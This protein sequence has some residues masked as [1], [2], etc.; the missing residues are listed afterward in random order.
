MC[1]MITSKGD[2]KHW[3]CGKTLGL[4]SN[5]MTLLGTAGSGRG[6]EGIKSIPRDTAY[7]STVGTSIEPGLFT[8]FYAGEAEGHYITITNHFPG[9][10]TLRH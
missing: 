10:I 5:L 7:H 3:D 9:S 8:S 2:R 6:R 1:Q 4:N